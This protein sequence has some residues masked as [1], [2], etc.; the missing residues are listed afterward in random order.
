[1]VRTVLGGRQSS[2]SELS[3]IMGADRMASPTPSPEWD[4][5]RTWPSSDRNRL[6]RFMGG[7]AMTPDQLATDLGLSVDQALRVWREACFVELDH[8]KSDKM[9]AAEW[10]EAE[11]AA[12]L[13]EI[14]G[15]QE[16]ADRL[17]VQVNTV[18]MWR[19]RNILPIPARVISGV[20]LWQTAVIDEWAEATGRLV[21]Q[22]EIPAF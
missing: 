15:P 19:K 22:V 4:E 3:R 17:A 13:A 18:H 8:G 1:M 5:W 11:I 2:V 10:R 16:I 12:A 6:K 14:V 20:P 7:G 21:E 9:D